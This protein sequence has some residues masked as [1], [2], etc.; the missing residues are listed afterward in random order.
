MPANFFIPPDTTSEILS[1]ARVIEKARRTGR[2]PS[3]GERRR[4]D[5][6]TDFLQAVSL[7][8]KARTPDSSETSVEERSCSSG[9]LGE[10]FLAGLDVMGERATLR[11]LTISEFRQRTRRREL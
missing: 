6:V 8:N 3:L 1:A 9:E 2:A 7:V 11:R 5:P 4:L 10:R